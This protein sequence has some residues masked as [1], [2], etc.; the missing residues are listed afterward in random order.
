MSSEE[1]KS[2]KVSVVDKPL[3][4]GAS[5]APLSTFAYLFSAM[6]QYHESKVDHIHDIENG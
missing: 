3:P 2:A 4:K 1:L 6:L 5:T